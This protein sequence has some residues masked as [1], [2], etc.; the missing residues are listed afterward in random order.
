MMQTPAFVPARPA[1]ARALATWQ[2]LENVESA[3]L[4]QPDAPGRW[5]RPW[6]LRRVSLRALRAAGQ[7][8]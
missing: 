4:R 7:A 6:W 1:T 8:T 5:S 3:R 2:R